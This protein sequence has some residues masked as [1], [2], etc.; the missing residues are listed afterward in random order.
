[1]GVGFGLGVGLAVGVAAG[2]GFAS[3]WRPCITS[4]KGGSQRRRHHK[5]K[6]KMEHNKNWNND[7]MIN[8]R[9]IS[10]NKSCTHACCKTPQMGDL[11]AKS[12]RTSP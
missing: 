10:R 5:L 1:M 7:D 12:V 2:V 3:L 4:V 8:A 9:R 6:K 11:M